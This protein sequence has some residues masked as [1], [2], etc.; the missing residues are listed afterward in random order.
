MKSVDVEINLVP[1]ISLLSVLI[2]A[3]LLSAV[4]IHVGSIDVKQAFGGQAAADA[5]KPVKL[6]LSGKDKHKYVLKI[7][8]APKSKY[9]SQSFTLNTSE[10][11]VTKRLKTILKKLVDENIKVDHV[12]F[13]PIASSEYQGLIKLMDNFKEQGINNIGINPL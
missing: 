2:C 8:N 9:A 3:L 6:V 13:S 1:F 4:W 5:K 12:V 7:E 11:K 10:K